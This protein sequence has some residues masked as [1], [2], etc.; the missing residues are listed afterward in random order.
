VR[1]IKGGAL[2]YSYTW[3]TSAHRIINLKTRLMNQFKMMRVIKLIQFLQ[4]K[5]RPIHSMARYLGISNRSVYRYLKMYEKIGYDVQ[6]D[7][8][9]KYY[10]NETL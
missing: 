8:N 9:Y 10:I 6:K 7:D 4:V 3:T 5:P 1:V 2:T